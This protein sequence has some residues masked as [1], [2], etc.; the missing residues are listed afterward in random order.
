MNVSMLATPY[1]IPWYSMPF[2]MGDGA[3]GM[4]CRH[5]SNR[6]EHGG[7]EV[8]DGSFGLQSLCD[9]R[10]PSDSL[11]QSSSLE[12][13]HRSRIRIPQLMTW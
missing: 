10:I 5:G 8:T 4:F 13:S 9:L 1:I 3:S 7:R 11:Y 6:Y 2:R 12:L